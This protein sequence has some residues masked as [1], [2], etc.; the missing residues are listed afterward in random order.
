MTCRC[1]LSPKQ[2]NFATT[3]S[4]SIHSGKTFFSFDE[5]VAQKASI[6]SF[7]HFENQI[8]SNITQQN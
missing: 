2:L 3:C 7:R 4:T 6:T 1:H 8:C 5:F